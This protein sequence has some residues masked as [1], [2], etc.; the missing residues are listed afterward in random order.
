MAE[1]QEAVVPAQMRAEIRLVALL[2]DMSHL[3]PHRRI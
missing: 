2:E 3:M 1:E